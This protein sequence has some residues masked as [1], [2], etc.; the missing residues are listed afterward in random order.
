M[1]SATGF[2]IFG[3]RMLKTGVRWSPGPLKALQ[4]ALLYADYGDYEDSEDSGGPG[5]ARMLKTGLRWSPGP[6][7]DL[8]AAL[9]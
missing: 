2:I 4:A 3:V 1:T 8:Q 7:K 5:R 6:F 9:L